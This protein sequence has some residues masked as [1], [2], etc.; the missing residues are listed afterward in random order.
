M[1]IKFFPKT[2]F[3][4]VRLIILFIILFCSLAIKYIIPFFFYISYKPIEG[5]IL[6]QRLYPFNDLVKAIEGVSNSKYSH[7]GV[8]LN[9]NGKWVVIQALS[10]VKLTPLRNWISQGTFGIFYVYRLKNNYSSNINIFIKKLKNYLGYPYDIKYNLNDDAIYCSELIF[11]AYKD[12]TG[13]EMGILYKLK[14]LNWKPWIKTIEKY[15]Q[16]PVPLN[17]VMITPY[18]L[19][20]AKQLELINQKM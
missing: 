18:N 2:S 6:F 5:D 9:E 17:R 10:E 20:K 1:K 12:A 13:E 14:D 11:K 7:C 15:E 4:K 8:V 19:S 16:G 3:E